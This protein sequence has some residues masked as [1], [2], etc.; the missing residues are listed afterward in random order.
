MGEPQR[1]RWTY[2]GTDRVVEGSPEKFRELKAT[3]GTHPHGTPQRV[4]D[5]GGLDSEAPSGDDEG[6]SVSSPPICG[7]ELSSGGTCSRQVDEAGDS[8]WQHGGD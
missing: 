7:A 8:C 1:I 4:D 5:A 6:P 3:V 2:P